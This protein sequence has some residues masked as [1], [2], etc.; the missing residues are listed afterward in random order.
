MY[1]DILEKVGL[2]SYVATIVS[3]LTDA[4]AKGLPVE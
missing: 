3:S 4:K 2:D 1:C